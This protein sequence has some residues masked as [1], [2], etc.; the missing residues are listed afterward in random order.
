MTGKPIVVLTSRTF[1]ETRAILEGRV[2]LVA[3]DALEPWSHEQVAERCQNAAGLMAFMTDKI[4]ASFLAACP[5]LRVI[6]AAL[7]G[8][9]N[10]DIEAATG[11][12]V[13]VTI[14]PDLL[15]VPT[16][17]LAIGLILGLG[18]HIVAGD[19]KIREHGFAGWRPCLYGAGLS[20]ASAG[21]VGFGRVGQAIARRLV[22]F[23]C[24]IMA[25]DEGV[26]Q[27]PSDLDGH[28]EMV[29]LDTILVEADYVVLAL[30]L[31][32]R[33]QHL[34]NTKTIG[35][36]KPGAML[37]NPARGSLVDERAVAEAIAS[38]HLAGY[39]ADVFECED[40]ARSDRPGGID[41]R[42]TSP[43]AP[44]VLTPHIGSAVTRVRREIE[45]SAAHSILDAL[46]G[47]VPPYAIND[48]R[49][50]SADAQPGAYQD[51]PS[52]P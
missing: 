4:D 41:A 34:M 18:R 44:T 50:R 5:D 9:D 42:L 35:R 52:S 46:N 28:V 27:P 7:K 15:T 6:G 38:G 24:R 31:T 14:V 37:I 1:P 12:G 23:D 3:N 26:L 2:K 47:R 13:W 40:W 16:A 19:R 48:P 20:E 10:I 29:S 21:L 36:M 11:A 32:P 25:F 45:L 17:E 8:H 51:V 30:P 43:R 49:K 39:A 22:G 33:T